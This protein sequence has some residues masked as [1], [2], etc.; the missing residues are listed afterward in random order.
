[1]S[2]LGVLAVRDREAVV[3][4]VVA[5]LLASSPSLVGLVVMQR[6]DR[7]AISLDVCHPLGSCEQSP[8]ILILAPA[9]HPPEFVYLNEEQLTPE[10]TRPAAEQFNEP[11]DPPPP[12]ALA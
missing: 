2:R 10:S 1:M 6:D 5:L 9:P 3:V 8:T 7:P 11:P 12:K 4:L